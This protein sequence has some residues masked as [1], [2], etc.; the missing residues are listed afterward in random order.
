MLKIKLMQ[1]NGEEK[2]FTQEFVSAKSF[3]KVI[4]FGVEAESGKLSELEQLDKMVSLVASLFKDEAVNFDSIY[5][6][7][8]TENF[9]DELQAVIEEVTNPISAKN[10]LAKVTK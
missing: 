8:S 5:E 6:G 10:S 3:R 2:T 9:I 7:L 1:A 4:E